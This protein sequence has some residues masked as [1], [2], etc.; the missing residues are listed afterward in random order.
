MQNINVITPELNAKTEAR[1]S[2]GFSV[3]KMFANVARFLCQ[4][5]AAMTPQP[6]TIEVRL[7]N[8]TMLTNIPN[9]VWDRHSA[10]I[11]ARYESSKRA[12]S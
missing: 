10:L 5:A 9:R 2:P 8:G 6:R 3:L 4:Y 1:R 7:S 11:S 12:G